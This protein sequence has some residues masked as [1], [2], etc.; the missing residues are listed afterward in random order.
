MSGRIVQIS[1]KGRTPGEQGLPKLPIP[2]ARVDARGVEGDYNVYRAERKHGDPDMAVLLMALE[3][4]RALQAEGWPVMAGHIGENLT[5][6]GVPYA[7]MQP[8]TR[9]RAGEVELEVSKPCE[10]CTNLYQL[11]YVGEARGP[12]FL[13]AI[14]GRRGWYA[15]VLREGEVRA[16]DAFAPLS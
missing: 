5:T 4:L 2:A 13:K 9:W 7:A 10:P 16:G 14:V 6:D 15:R 12:A 11:P 3:E 8:G 1:V